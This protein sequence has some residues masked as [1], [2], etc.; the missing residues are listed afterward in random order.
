MSVGIQ[1][2]GDWL[3]V[4]EAIAAEDGVDVETLGEEISQVLTAKPGATSVHQSAAPGRPPPCTRRNR[5]SPK[6]RTLSAKAEDG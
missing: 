3:E 6:I 5:S 2:W 4:V 1:G